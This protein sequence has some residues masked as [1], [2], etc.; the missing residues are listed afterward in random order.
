MNYKVIFS[1]TQ[2]VCAE[3]V[4]FV[5]VVDKVNLSKT[6]FGSYRLEVQIQSLNLTLSA[7]IEKRIASFEEEAA[8]ARASRP[9]K[10][11]VMKI[12]GW[13]Q[14]L[15]ED[16]GGPEAGRRWTREELAQSRLAGSW[17]LAVEGF[18]YDVS[19]FADIH[20]GGRRSLM[21]SAGGDCTES[22]QLVHQHV[23]HYSIMKC[24]CRGKL[25]DAA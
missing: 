13:P 16:P 22:Y 10:E 14:N 17:L 2:Q 24:V 9:P 25:V 8:K 11:P 5:G 3:G 23:D 15:P 7:D 1:A 19:L 4:G 21:Q 6:G 12:P 18:V 20:P